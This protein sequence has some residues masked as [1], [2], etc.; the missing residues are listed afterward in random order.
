MNP[1][2]A[3]VPA[4]ADFMGP[5]NFASAQ[6]AHKR[7]ART[8]CLLAF[9]AELGLKM[10]AWGNTRANPANAMM[11]AGL[12]DYYGKSGQGQVL[13]G[14]EHSDREKNA[15]PIASPALSLL[16]DTTPETWYASLDERQTS[17]GLAGRFIPINAGSERGEYNEQAQFAEPDPVLLAKL[18]NLVSHCLTSQSQAF[19]CNVPLDAEAKVLSR[20][21]I[22]A[23]RTKING[24]DSEVKRHLE[25]RVHLNTLKLAALYAIG[26][27]AVCDNI[28][29]EIENNNLPT[30][31][32]NAFSW[33]AVIV[34]QGVGEMVSRFAT[35]EV[36]EEQGN[37]AKQ[38]NEVIRVIGE[39]VSN[40]FD[41]VAAKYSRFFDMHAHGVITEAYIQ[42]RLITLKAFQPRAKLAIK[43]SLKALLEADDL[44]EMPPTQMLEK[45]GVKPRAFV[46]SN[47]DRF[48]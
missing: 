28:K 44:R 42:R 21:L 2:I 37:E 35:G 6:A 31:C 24:A 17:N 5:S 11:I 16:G 39:Y 43:E 13:Q 19:V 40:D 45:Y 27:F 18:E 3:N 33:G 9:V 32:P 36:G 8:P 23:T 10:Q 12:L 14:Q 15:A 4:A 1:V 29:E 47:P 25:G 38:I 34:Q 22:D 30:I 7:L 20:R 48:L 41:T 26:R 46:I